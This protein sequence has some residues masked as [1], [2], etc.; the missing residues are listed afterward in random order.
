MKKV[1]KVI[2]MFMFV[3]FATNVNAQ[4][5]TAATATPAA[6]DNKNAP[7]FKFEVEEYNFGKIKQ[8]ES[9]TYEFKF[10]NTGKEPLLISEAHG[11]CGCTV[12]IWPKEPIA[13]GK[14]GVI[15]VTFNSAGKMGI[16]DK[17]VTLSS[18]SKTPTKVIHMKGEVLPAD[19]APATTPPVKP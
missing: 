1:A 17:T 8:G 4:D 19:P 15:K 12:P 14:E 7:D 5:K 18:N 10:K 2:G 6:A 13:K 11:S 9:A 3:A 16:Q